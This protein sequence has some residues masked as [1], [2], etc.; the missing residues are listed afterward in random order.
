M[1][2][3]IIIPCLPPK[4]TSQQKGASRTGSGIRFYKKA[5]VL[6]A[7]N[8]IL[9]L[10]RPHAPAVPC[11]GPLAVSIAF[12]FPWRKGEK[13]GVIAKF[14]EY[15]ITT[16]PDCS[17]IVK[18]VEDAMTRLNFWNDDGQNSV[19]H[20]SKYYADSPGFTINIKSAMGVSRDGK[21]IEV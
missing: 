19:L 12:R 20:V 13:K 2:I 1:N 11:A 8:D 9:S 3:T 17:N 15:P 16:K 21:L 4:A 10:L 6:A 5:H 7:E 18:M 14:A